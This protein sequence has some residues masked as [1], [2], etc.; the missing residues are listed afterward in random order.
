MGKEELIKLLTE[1]KKNSMNDENILDQINDI[2]KIIAL[3]NQ[4]EEE[5][6]NFKKMLEEEPIKDER[7]TNLE[8]IVDNSRILLEENKEALERNKLIVHHINLDTNLIQR[9]ILLFQIKNE[10][11]KKNISTVDDEKYQAKFNEQINGNISKISELNSKIE[12]NNNLVNRYNEYIVVLEEKNEFLQNQLNTNISNLDQ[13]KQTL[14]KT[15]NKTDQLNNI[16]QAYNGLD[17]VLNN[18]K[19]NNYFNNLNKDIDNKEI[20]NGLS[21]YKDQVSKTLLLNQPQKRNDEIN[22]IVIAK[23]YYE[24]KN[25]NM[26]NIQKEID[27]NKNE[28]KNTKVDLKTKEL[29]TQICK[30]DNNY[31]SLINYNEYLN[32]QTNRI[33]KENEILKFNIKNNNNNE[34]KIQLQ[35]RIAE[36][37]K[38]LSIIKNELK[39]NNKFLAENEKDKNNCQNQ[40][41]LYNSL[42]NDDKKN[43]N[44]DVYDYIYKEN[45]NNNAL[46]VNALNTRERFLKSEIPMLLH[47]WNE[48]KSK[49]GLEVDNAIEGEFRII[50]DEKNNPLLEQPNNT[51]HKS[52][53][54]EDVNISSNR[55]ENE[56][57]QKQFE[58]VSIKRPIK[59]K[60]ISKI[61]KMSAIIIAGMIVLSTTMP[62]SNKN[63][64]SDNSNTKIVENIDVE[65]L[66][67]NIES[68]DVIDEIKIDDTITIKDG[69][70]IYYTQYDATEKNN[71]LNPIND[72]EMERSIIGATLK[73]PDG[74]LK[75]VQNNKELEKLIQDGAEITS[76]L[77]G[78][79]HEAEGFWNV[80]DV[81]KVNKIENEI[82]GIR[83]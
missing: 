5:M 79:D 34:Q 55:K 6:L 78:N 28:I 23:N 58:I 74:S 59:E 24:T 18:F 56:I 70:S 44:L 21:V 12:N 80:N 64:L 52:D 43:I 77:T 10:E 35:N 38:R 15:D 81:N 83:R 53:W 48:K 22:K 7:L 31:N 36:N 30:I 62:I 39:S 42:I 13:Y 1:L 9:E 33:N 26:I 25:D 46:I 19:Y 72:N 60:I 65:K 8:E 50:E 29:Q 76:Y 40:I 75:F 47:N 41:V 69:A 63:D 49:M 45:K 32:I 71:P 17:L 66:T 3:K 68:D 67:P 16:T 11:L 82:G 61:K 20:L 51:D 2:E 57:E 27:K 14:E 73:M 37:E 4:K 54:V